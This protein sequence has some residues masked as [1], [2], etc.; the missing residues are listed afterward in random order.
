MNILITGGGSIGKRHLKNLQ[1]LGYLNIWVLKRQPD[2][3]F[4]NEHR[5]KVITSFEEAVGIPFDILIVG[6]PTSL[7]NES[8][9][10]AVEQGL[11]VFMEKP[12]IDNQ[13]GLAQAKKILK[14]FEGIFFIGFM[15]RFHPLVQ[16]IKNILHSQELGSV[17]SA[18]FEFGSYLP[19]WHPWE[20]YK[21]SYAS[22]KELGGGVIN[23]ITHELDLIQYFFGTPDSI[24]CEACNLQ[25]LDI[26]VEEL[27]EAIFNYNDKTIT[28]HLDYLQKDYDRNIK[29][30]CENGKIIWNWHDNEV[31]VY[32]HKEESVTY[33]INE[34]FD[35]NQLYID[36]LQDFLQR[37]QNIETKHPLDFD[38]AVQNTELMLLM[39]QS[40]S[41]G[42]KI[43]L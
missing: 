32:I 13:V 36:E 15:L 14:N 12:L 3:T 22:R 7:H 4:E 19:Y 20:D 25:R 40:A 16:K 5:V 1:Q 33:S 18:R 41:E 39:H 42:K 6:T 24:Y 23:T 29:I 35:V 26:E 43:H 21:I 30:L 11:H 2:S 10:F 27:A 38:H 8:L 37:I 31:K 28:L 9:Q 34:T 17:Y